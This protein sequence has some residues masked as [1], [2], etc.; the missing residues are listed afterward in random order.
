[1]LKIFIY[2]ILLLLLSCSSRFNIANVAAIKRNVTTTED[3]YALFGNPLWIK[4]EFPNILILYYVEKNDNGISRTLIIK[5][6]KRNNKV[7]N[8]KIREGKIFLIN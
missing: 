2:S 5:I 8:W 6:N 4:E 7:M 3:I 1:M